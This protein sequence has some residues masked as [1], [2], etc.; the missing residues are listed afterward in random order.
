MINDLNV[1]N[2]QMTA[3]NDKDE[4]LYQ[5]LQLMF[6]MFIILMIGAELLH[7]I[8]EIY[9]NKA[10][11]IEKGVED[12]KSFYDQNIKNKKKNKLKNG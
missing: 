3:Y 7:F 9:S 6:A 2:D 4:Q 8:S 11:R 5:Q 10:K 1:F 12:V